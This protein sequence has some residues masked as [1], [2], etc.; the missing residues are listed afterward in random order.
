MK[1]NLFNLS[2]SLF[3]FKLFRTFGFPNILPFSLSFYF[4][5]KCNSKCKTC[6]IWKRKSKNELSMAEWEKILKNI[7]NSPLFVT[8]AGGEPFLRNDLP[9]FVTLICRYIN[10]YQI[11]I[12]T[13]GIFTQ[14]I[15]RDVLKISDICR[16]NR[17]R[18]SINVSLDA[19]GMKYAFLRGKNSFNSVL[20]TIKLLKKIK[21]SNNYLNIGLN[22]TVSKYNVAQFDELLSY[23]KNQIQPDYIIFEFAANRNAFSLKNKK[24]M[25][26]DKQRLSI[27]DNKALMIQLNKGPSILRFFRNAYYSMLYY[28]LKENKMIVPCYAAIASSEINAQG[29]VLTCCS[30]AES[31]GNLSQNNYDFKK[32][33][34][35]RKAHKIRQ[36]I[37]QNKCFCNAVNP[38]YTNILLTPKLRLF[39]R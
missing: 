11:N 17:T 8:I 26:S 38:N 2:Y 24:I 9:E 20:K 35:S 30:E 39:K 27:L 29:D 25:L 15:S 22:I 3:K 4:T 18:L 21:K 19:L 12:A 1:L 10:P 33:W 28:Q 34:F 7:G 36:R 13:N 5:D 16:N 14:K 23:I 31:M 32:V 37:K 6:N